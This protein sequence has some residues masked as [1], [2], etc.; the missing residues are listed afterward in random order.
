MVLLKIRKFLF[1]IWLCFTIFIIC[2]EVTVFFSNR[3]INIL[4]SRPIINNFDFKTLFFFQIQF[5]ELI[6]D[7]MFR[8]L[9]V[10]KTF[11]IKVSVKLMFI[12]NYMTVPWKNLFFEWKMHHWIK[13]INISMCFRFR[14]SSI[15]I[16][17]W[18]WN[19]IIDKLIDNMKEK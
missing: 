4:G 17:W 18:L 13:H 16:E 8:L 7:R 12:K 10:S 5:I 3:L 2:N 19:R 6:I 1:D 14:F 11:L 9:I 15:F